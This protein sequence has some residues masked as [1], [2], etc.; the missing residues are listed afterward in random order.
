MSKYRR[1]SS[2][3]EIHE[4][5]KSKKTQDEYNNPAY[6]NTTT[7]MEKLGIKI[8]NSDVF[9]K[10]AAS[11]INIRKSKAPIMYNNS[12]PEFNEDEEE[13]INKKETLCR[14]QQKR[15]KNSIKN[16]IRTENIINVIKKK[17]GLSSVDKRIVKKNKKNNDN[18]N[19]ISLVKKEKDKDKNKDEEII[20]KKTFKSKTSIEKKESENLDNKPNKKNKENTENKANKGNEEIKK[21]KSNKKQKNMSAEKIISSSH[22][23]N[24]NN[25]DSKPNMDI[26][27]SKKLKE[28]DLNKKKEKEKEKEIDKKNENNEEK[29]VERK[30]KKNKAQSMEKEIGIEQTLKFKE[31]LLFGKRK[32]SLITGDNSDAEVEESSDSDSDSGSSFSLGNQ[33]KSKNQSKTQVPDIKAIVRSTKKH[34]TE[35][36]SQE[37]MAS[38]QK[39]SN[40]KRTSVEKEKE[41]DA[42]K[43]S[44]PKIVAFRHSEDNRKNSIIFGSKYLKRRSMDNEKVRDRLEQLMNEQTL[45]QNGGNTLFLRNFEKGPVYQKEIEFIIKNQNIKKNIKIGSCTKAGCSGPGIVKT[46]QDAYFI[47]ENFLKNSNNLFLGVCDGHGIKGEIIS[48]YVVNKLPEYIKDINNDS[49][50]NEFKKINKEIYSNSN[51][52]SDMAGTTVVSVILTP[53]KMMCVNLGD[54]RAAVFKYEN[55]LYYCKNLSR[56]HKPNEPD[57]NKR[58]LFNNGRIKKCF[59]EDIKKFVG[60][61]RVWL[62]N[63]EEPGLAMSR[64]LGDKIAHTIGVSDEPEIKCYDYDGTEKFIVIASDGI[65]EY[66]HG[67]ECIKV[68]KSYYEDNKD[69]EEAAFAMVKEAFRKWKRKEV[70]IDDITVIVLFFDD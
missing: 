11:N 65:W 7:L 9:N 54:S 3:A 70:A 16:E 67:D 27:K 35:M 28:S 55:G 6:V 44:Q 33:N 64:S 22:Y 62:K 69:V 10:Q 14:S 59:D 49:I 68:I 20:R 36:A 31:K 21:T 57:E 46:N 63:K 43:E 17:D 30:K 41:V 18:R 61:D 50:I 23:Q 45:K 2:N 13:V 42:E 38:I 66:V 40:K 52:E 12:I 29:E 53:E 26:H 24:L 4:K 39:N 58:I 8:N 60:P 37:D 1:V 5:K 19:N 15:N 56:D 25:D 51:I 47:K 48:N 32:K 34:V